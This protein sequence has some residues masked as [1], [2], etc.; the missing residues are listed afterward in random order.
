MNSYHQQSNL[1]SDGEVSGE[2][3][4]QCEPCRRERMRNRPE[5]RN[6]L[7]GHNAR[8]VKREKERETDLEGVWRAVMKGHAEVE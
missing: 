6:A 5:R 4:A 2:G 1:S 3:S 8:S 7:R